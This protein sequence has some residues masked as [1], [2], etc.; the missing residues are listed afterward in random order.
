MIVHV[1]TTPQCMSGVYEKNIKYQFSASLLLFL[2]IVIQVGMEC[3]NSK[4][5]VFNLA[6]CEKSRK[7]SLKQLFSI[8]NCSQST[9]TVHCAD[10]FGAE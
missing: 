5:N 3:V 1:G 10:R 7:N 6:K 8:S 2:L 9:A 4:I